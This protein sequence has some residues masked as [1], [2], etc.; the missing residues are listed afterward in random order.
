MADADFFGADPD[1]IAYWQ[2]QIHQH[3]YH[4]LRGHSGS[5]TV[6]LMLPDRCLLDIPFDDM[7]YLPQNGERS[8]K[9]PGNVTN[10]REIA[11]LDHQDQDENKGRIAGTFK[12]FLEHDS[13]DK[14]YI[15]PENFLE[16]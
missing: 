16:T 9:R 14:W 2:G 12:Y 10:G 7:P 11:P 6:F 13:G 5:L 8:K 15:D 1:K 4:A 3:Y